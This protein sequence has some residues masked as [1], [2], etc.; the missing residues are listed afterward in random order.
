MW[1]T[2]DDL[3]WFEHLLKQGNTSRCHENHERSHYIHFTS[4]FVYRTPETSGPTRY[5][6]MTVM[7]AS[8]ES[9]RRQA[10]HIPCP[11][12]P[13]GH[14]TRGAAPCLLP[15]RGPRAL[16]LFFLRS[17]GVSSCAACACCSAALAASEI[18]RTIPASPPPFFIPSDSYKSVIGPVI[19]LA[20][21]VFGSHE[22]AG[23]YGIALSALGM[24]ATLATCLT[25]D[26]YGP[27]CDNAGGIAEM[28]ELH[29]EV[30]SVTRG[31][32]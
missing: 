2:M 5:L 3:G 27:V 1:P 23:M 22:F 10:S 12:M 13:H 14:A 15:C 31:G 7:S 9:V 32:L 11:H 30:R 8:Q 19:I 4:R 6:L 17:A 29:P 18:L 20:A 21:I 28:C 16:P 25:I 26:V 24:L